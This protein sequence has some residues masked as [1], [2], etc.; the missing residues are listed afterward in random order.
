MDRRSGNG[1]EQQLPDK[2]TSLL[3][4]V[5]FN[6]V[7]LAPLVVGGLSRVSSKVDILT[8]DKLNVGREDRTTSAGRGQYGVG[9]REERGD[10]TGSVSDRGL[11]ERGERMRDVCV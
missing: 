3:M 1:W 5:S 8:W 6:G 11:L 4:T 10:S 9:F 7:P 2:H